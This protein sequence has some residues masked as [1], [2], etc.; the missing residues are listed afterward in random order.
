MSG[1]IPREFI[2]E[3]LVRV[4]IVDLIDSYVPLKK[5]GSNFT[6]RCPFHSEKT[7]SFSVSPKKQF[8]HCFGCGASGNAISF[9]MDFDH[10]NFVEAVES[11]ASFAGLDVP[12]ETGTGS[13]NLKS[14]TGH[15]AIALEKAASLYA[16]QLRNTPE[17][18]KAVAYLKN[19]GISSQVAQDYQ[20]GYAPANSMPIFSRL[21]QDDLLAAGI[22][23]RSDKGEIYPRFRNRVMFPIRDKRG[24]T[25]GFGGRV[26]DDSLP[27]YLNSPETPLFH[28]GREVYGLYELLEE[29][30][31]PE[32]I[33][34]T[35]GYMDVIALAQFGIRFAVATLGTA[36]TQAHFEL[37]FRFTAELVLC[38]DGDNA[39]RQAVWRAIEAAMPCLRD[40]RQLR[41]LLL[42]QGQDPDSLVREHG[43]QHFNTLIINA[44]PLSDYFFQQQLEGLNLAELEARA[45]LLNNCRPYLE[46][47]PEGVFKSMMFNRLKDLAKS[48]ALE[49]IVKP[50]TL[51]TSGSNKS[52]R[53]ELKHSPLRTVLALLIQNPE[54]MAIIEDKQTAWEE[55]NFRGA[56]VFITIVST[57]ETLKLANTAALIEH[58]RNSEHE[59]IIKKLAAME[60]PI[61]E[62]GINREF[63]DS[64]DR[65][66][67][68][69]K[70]AMYNKLLAKEKN[71]TEGEKKLLGKILREYKQ[72]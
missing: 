58:F 41:I 46:K 70:E 3:L 48:D 62:E 12:R 1:R 69:G 60:L 2:N 25:I 23:G 64:L 15:L 24:R 6:A 71:L 40:G 42:P 31:K 20:L 49:K 38:F 13:G 30:P 9:L 4:D 32:R 28:K 29:T 7:P 44:L 72:K 39:G 59:T 21:D 54:L 51:A 53:T 35:E 56:E 47:L 17:G 50:G 26:L 68:Q 22:L 34:V 57:I 37:L 11:L 16:A 10:L 33:I 63:S 66:I 67:Q 36:A 18:K 52:Q 27:K 43:N 65:I 55:L 19:R 14:E 8:F 5:A 45:H 61:P